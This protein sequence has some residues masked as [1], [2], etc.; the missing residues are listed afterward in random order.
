MSRAAAASR[1]ACWPHGV[2]H[3]SGDAGDQRV[4]RD[5]QQ[6]ADRV[7]QRPLSSW[8]AAVSR[9][10]DVFPS[11]RR[12]AAEPSGSRAVMHSQNCT[13]GSSSVPSPKTPGVRSVFATEV[14]TPSVSTIS[15][16][17][18]WRTTARARSSPGNTTSADGLPLSAGRVTVCPARS[19][20]RQEPSG[21]LTVRMPTTPSTG[22]EAGA[23]PTV[24]EGPS[25]P[26]SKALPSGASHSAS[27]RKAGMLI[28]PRLSV[29][30]S[31]SYQPCVSCS[32]SAIHTQYEA[33]SKTSHRSSGI[34]VSPACS[35]PAPVVRPPPGRG[36]VSLRS[37]LYQSISV[38]R[39][40]PGPSMVRGLSAR[41]CQ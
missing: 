39:V 38:P 12:S 35:T 7:G 18:P 41:V 31:Y 29:V 15:S 25:Q 17:Q 9:A 20:L 6:R 34:V 4:V 19:W 13:G 24:G 23:R 27:A 36:R 14:T 3:D 8:A 5:R 37:A 33:P 40:P 32:P 21:S 2:A 26:L 11:M 1:T 10:A 30:G 16:C 28:R 22:A